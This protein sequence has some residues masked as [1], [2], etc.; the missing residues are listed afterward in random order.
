MNVLLIDA[1]I[2]FSTIYRAMESD[3]TLEPDLFFKNCFGSIKKSMKIN[4]PSYALLCVDDLS[5]SW[6]RDVLVEYRKNRFQM[7]LEYLAK[8]PS[9][10]K[11]LRDIGLN[12]NVS[13]SY[14]SYDIIAT[15]V[16]KLNNSGRKSNI[17]IMSSDT[18]IYSLLFDNVEIYNPFSRDVSSIRKDAKWL[19]DNLE[20]TYDSYLMYSCLVGN[21]AKNI[22]GIP[23]VGPKN[24]LKLTKEYKDLKTLNKEKGGI[25]SAIGRSLREN[26]VSIVDITYGL[27]KLNNNIE[28]GFL[29]G[30]LKVQ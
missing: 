14:E 30:S 3:G 11:R 15:M 12:S 24:A 8:M 13:A 27:H 25:D 18:R 21:K 29:L 7:P 1:H 23:G 10:L 2:V 17:T 4:Q 16:A 22:P 20:L 6:R 9:F 19:N 26:L 5:R 28:L